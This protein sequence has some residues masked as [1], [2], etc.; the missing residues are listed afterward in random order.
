MIRIDSKHALILAVIG[1]G[2]L[3]GPAPAR[4]EEAD[5]LDTLSSEQA[6]SVATGYE[7]PVNLAPVVATV[8]SAEDIK[9]MGAT[10]IKEALESVPGLHVSTVDG[11]NSVTRDRRHQLPYLGHG[12]QYF[13]SARVPQCLRYQGRPPLERC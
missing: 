6:G 9:R 12:K 2:A 10:T 1:M 5:I 13:P 4:A 7:K 3:N 11:I 8:I